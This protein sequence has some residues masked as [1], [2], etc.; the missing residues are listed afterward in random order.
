MRSPGAQVDLGLLRQR[1]VG[2]RGEDVDGSARSN[3][4]SAVISLVVLAIGRRSPTSL[5][6]SVVP[7]PASITTRRR[8]G[9]R[10]DR[11]GRRVRPGRAA[12]TAP[13]PSPRA[14]APGASLAQL[15]LLA[16]YERLGVELRVQLQQRL[17]RHAGLLRDATEGVAHLHGVGVARGPAR[18]RGALAVSVVSVRAASVALASAPLSLAVASIA[19]T[20]PRTMAAQA[21]RPARRAAPA[22]AAPA[23]RCGL[24]RVRSVLGDNARPALLP[25]DSAGSSLR[26][27]GRAQSAQAA[28]RSSSAAAAAAAAGSPPRSAWAFTIERDAVTRPAA[29]CGA[30]AGPRSSTRPPCAPTPGSRKIARGISS[31]RRPSSAGRGGAGDRAHAR[32]PAV[33]QACRA[34]LVDQPR[35]PLVQRRRRRRPGAPRRRGSRCARARS[36]PAPLPR[37]RLHERLERVAAEQ[38]VGGEGVG[39]QAGHGAERARRSR[40]RAPARRRRAVTGTSPRLPSAITSSPARA[41]GRGRLLE[42][43]P[44]GGAEP[45]E[46][47]ELELDGH[48]RR[49]GGLDGG[50]RSGARPRRRWPRPDRSSAGALERRRPE[51]RRVGV[52]PQHDLAA[53]LLY[54]RRKPVGEVLGGLSRP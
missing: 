10:R 27:G 5:P 50:A 9:A 36:R 44:A 19:G 7:S 40:P 33:R 39:A 15:D 37:G 1:V 22:R 13:P 49:P 34:E 47:G 26:R 11:R 18:G 48:A 3:A 28:A 8:R 6:K 14:C 12:P 42:R 31:R 2:G 21:A 20:R 46:A 41:R 54:E 23:E 17:H 43:P 16:G 4:S 25:A 35:E 30:K 52:E 53:A 38:R 29:G 45:L 32:E 24:A 51:G